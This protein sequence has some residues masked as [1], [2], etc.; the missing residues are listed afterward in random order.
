MQEALGSF[1]IRA[2]ELSAIML[3]QIEDPDGDSYSVTVTLGE[4]I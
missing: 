4:V 3:P 2:T 1:E